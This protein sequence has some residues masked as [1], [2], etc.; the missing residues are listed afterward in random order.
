MASAGVALLV[1]V[2]FGGWLAFGRDKAPETARPGQPDNTTP[3]PVTP[4]PVDPK[5]EPNVDPKIEPPKV[6]PPVPGE[7]VL[8]KLDLTGAAPFVIKSQ[9][10]VDPS[11]PN[12]KVAKV[13]AQAGTGLAPTGWQGRAY[14]KDAVMEFFSDALDGRFAL[15]IRNTSGP[16]SAMLFTPTVET[17][18]GLFRLKFEYQARVANRKFILR[19]KA[20]DA[21]P[22]WDIARPTP[23][24]DAWRVE[25][26][27]VDTKG[28][29]G[30][31]EFHNTD[32]QANAVIRIR[33]LTLTEAPVGTAP[34]TI[35]G[36]TPVP[37]TGPDYKA[38]TEGKSVYSLDV[39]K[40][41]VLRVTKERTMRT[42]G[43]PEKLP[44]G[45]G[46]QA[47]KEGGIGEFRRDEFEGFAALGLTNLNDVKSAQYTFSL[48]GTLKVQLKPGQVYRV[49]V[50]YQTAQES[51][52]TVTVQLA[53]G[54]KGI[55]SGLLATT[56]GQWKTATA[57]FTR[58]PAE[59]KAEVRMV[60]ENTTA[61]EG[62]TLWVKSVE[63]VELNP[64]KK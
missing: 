53:P 15:G 14:G 38:W 33:A 36:T 37:P 12:K 4:K 6:V 48:E 34:T 50:G 22:A 56:N 63:I 11:D 57:T 39:V 26:F 55:G 27:V 29:G 40:I 31:F 30:L 62:N 8:Y 59:D 10:T 17:K 61:G 19:F 2:G 13:L 54:F 45:V 52:G 46:C 51:A 25:E 47:W 5:I 32:D 49:K 23:S 7:R 3:P 42:A 1:A 16:P 18:T 41:P 58:P 44:P 64:P 24:G 60:V 28:T 21:R 43:E 35:P 20:N 9:N